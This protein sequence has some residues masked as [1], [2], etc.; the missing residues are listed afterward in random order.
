MGLNAFLE[1][2]SPY[3]GYRHVGILKFAL[4]LRV[5]I[6][7]IEPLVK[8]RESSELVVVHVVND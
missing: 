8:L 2:V 6:V 3:S 1:F 5:R 4:Q 7:M